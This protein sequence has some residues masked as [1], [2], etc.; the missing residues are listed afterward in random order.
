MSSYDIA[1]KLNIHYPIILNHLKKASY[2]KKKK[3]KKLDIW[4]R[5]DTNK[6]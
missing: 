3:E 1:K 6:L 5:I 4:I 2:K